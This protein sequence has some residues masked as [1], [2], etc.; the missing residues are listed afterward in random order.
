MKKLEENLTKLMSFLKKNIK[1]KGYPPTVREIA[2]HLDVKSTCTINYYLKKLE[3]AGKI[4]RNPLK[5]RAIEIIESDEIAD[6]DENLS[7][8]DFQNIPLVGRVAAGEPILAIS[9]YEDDF[10]IPKKMF[11]SGDLFMLKVRGDS[12]VEAGILE[13]DYV[14]VKKQETA[15]NGEI[16]VAMNEQSVTVKTF[17]KEKN[18]IRLQPENPLLAPIFLDSVDILGK[19]VGIIRRY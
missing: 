3:E 8:D 18:R 13:D 17:Y 19:V 2:S 14:V 12:M 16:V 1:D 10:N 9:N 6:N 15:N 7:R 11:G 5:N 4:K